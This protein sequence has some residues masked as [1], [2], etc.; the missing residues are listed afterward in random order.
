MFKFED[1]GV[2]AVSLCLS[3]KIRV[4]S[5][6]SACLNFKIWAFRAVSACLNFMLMKV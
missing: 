5:F 6:I 4:F 3:L 2:R 1:K